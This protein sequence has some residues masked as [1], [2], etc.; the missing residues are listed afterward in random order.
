MRNRVCESH[1]HGSVGGLGAF[2]QVYPDKVAKPLRLRKVRLHNI[3]PL[4]YSLRLR[5][6]AERRISMNW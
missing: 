3:L 6:F 1:S 5:A 4:A 2:A